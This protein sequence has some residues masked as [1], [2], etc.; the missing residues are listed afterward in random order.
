[1][2]IYPIINT[3]QQVLDKKQDNSCHTKINQGSFRE[4]NELPKS[5]SFL[6]PFKAHP[7]DFETQLTSLENVHCPSC[8]IKMLSK[9][10]HR[11]I[12][13]D[14]EKTKNLAEYSKVLNK[15]IESLPLNYRKLAT[16]L[17]EVADR[18]PNMGIHDAFNITRAGANC[19]MREELKKTVIYL[20]E[21]QKENKLSEQDNEA[22]NNYINELNEY[23]S[24]Q[25]LFKMKDFKDDLQKTVDSMETPKK[26]EMYMQVKE[27]LQNAYRYKTILNYK[28][29]YAKGQ[30]EG[31][32]ILENILKYSDSNPYKLF[33]NIDKVE[34]FNTILMCSQCKDS[35]HSYFKNLLD[36]NPSMEQNTKKYLNDIG[37]ATVANKLEGNS[38]Y[39]KSVLSGIK[40]ASGGRISHRTSDISGAAAS[41][42]FNEN[43][44]TYRF[45]DYEDIPCACCGG[46]TI[47]HEQK[48][49]IYKEIGECK[50]LCEV[51]NVAGMYSK[52]IMPQYKIVFER[53]KKILADNPDISEKDMMHSLR[54]MSKEDIKKACLQIKKEI[55]EESSKRKLNSFD[56]ELV[57]DFLYQLDTKYSK[58]KPDSEFSYDDFD[59]SIHYSL[60]KMQSDVRIKLATNAK[61][62]IRKLYM[63]DLIVIPQNNV[64]LKLGSNANA[65]FQNIFKMSI[66]TVDHIV[67]KNEGGGEEDENKIGYCKDCN[68]EKTDTPFYAWYKY[69][70]ELK[71]NTPKHLKRVDEIIKEEKISDMRFYTADVIKKMNNLTKGTMHPEFKMV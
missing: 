4:I 43:R 24:K 46:T 6:L 64:V 49:K 14:A 1:M 3:K 31:A 65:M 51:K 71:I 13:R 47:T 5:Y 35:R 17:N 9:D 48:L 56:R 33:S 11:A 54:V 40:A 41:K 30:S 62:R 39:L 38:N 50:T 19:M 44:I 61:N 36:N 37:N 66:L 52:N 34:P 32:F 25:K 67:P 70:P 16:F 58:I 27:N 53:Y 29:E 21:M 7:R 23:R 63:R 69:H 57:E 15:N 12:I 45:E 59:K 60:D 28:P 55:L 42:I 22:I 26:W 68:K 18:N 10:E 2:K 8:G 20:R